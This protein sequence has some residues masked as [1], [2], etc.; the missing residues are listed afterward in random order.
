MSLTL[1]NK[2]DMLLTCLLFSEIVSKIELKPHFYCILK[3]ASIVAL[4]SYVS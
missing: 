1:K 4:P 3:H 2:E